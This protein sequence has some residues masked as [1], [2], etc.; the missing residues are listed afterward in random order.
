M[1]S[2]KLRKLPPGTRFRLVSAE[3]QK[4]FPGTYT[5]AAE[6]PWDRRSAACEAEDGS[7]VLISSLATV[8]VVE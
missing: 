5:V 7:R 2:T 3:Q 8:E 1:N 4:K 6:R